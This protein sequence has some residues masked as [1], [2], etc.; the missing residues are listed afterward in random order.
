ML[1]QGDDMED[2][3]NDKIY[4]VTGGTQGIGAAAAVALARAGAKGVVICGRDRKRGAEVV[5]AIEAEACE[6]E[7]VRAD[8]A[9]AEECRAVVAACDARFGRIDGLVNAAGLTDRGT[10]EDT[11]IEL[12]DRMFAV[13][14]RAPFIL[15]QDAIKLMKR[16][17][18][19]GGIVNII[20]M[21]SH[22]GQP[23]LTAYSASKGALATLTRNVAHA[24]R[25]NR[26]RVNGINMGWA[27]TPNEDKVQ[28]ADGQPAD[29]LATAEAGQ[30]FG[31][32]IKPDDIARLCV[33]LLGPQSG[34]M[35][36]SVIDYDQNVMGAY[37]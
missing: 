16:E 6:A 8:L 32:L 9:V 17:G 13:N 26:I 28:S 27:D 12:W 7:F 31:R 23:F 30:P 10:I 15:M 21:S 5:A 1:A 2:G 14:T 3:F 22:G 36:G 25:G 34:L 18:T 4:V 19:A 11:G 29:W 35:T 20:T 37:D 24:M 33:F